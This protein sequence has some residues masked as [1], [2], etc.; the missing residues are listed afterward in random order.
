MADGTSIDAIETGEVGNAADADRMQAILRDMDASGADIKAGPRQP[1]PTMMSQ[2]THQ[3]QD[4]MMMPP[5]YNPAMMQ[6]QP[7]PQ[8]RYIQMEDDTNYRPKKRRNLWSD[9][10]E[11]IRDPIIVSVLIFVL[12][13][14]VLHTLLNKYAAWAFAVGGQLSWLGLIALSAVA[15][16]TFGVYQTGAHLLGL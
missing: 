5:M 13:L 9:I 7:P 3:P 12:S 6:Q 10:L 1:M 11:R 4:Q 15:G 2:M 8:Q 14:P 16:S